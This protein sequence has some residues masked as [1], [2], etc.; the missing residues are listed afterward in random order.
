MKYTDVFSKLTFET[1]IIVFMK[2]NGDFRVML[3][4][5]NI[6]TAS[7]KWDFLGGALGGHDKRCSIK[8]GNIAVIDLL[9]GEVRSFN[10][11]RLTYIEYV[12]E[13]RN[14]EDLDTAAERFVAFKESYESSIPKEITMEDL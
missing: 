14:N 7:L 9:L 13:I 8:N 5:R 1:A 2:K 4:T 6:N 3:G 10:I 12:G 11:D